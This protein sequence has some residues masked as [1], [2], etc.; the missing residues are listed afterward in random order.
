LALTRPSN[1]GLDDHDAVTPQRR[2]DKDGHNALA[3]MGSDRHRPKFGSDLMKTVVLRLLRGVP[4]LLY[5]RIWQNAGRRGLTL[6]RFAETEADG[7]RD[8]ARAAEL[9]SDPLLRRLYLVHANDER[10]HAE[11][12]RRRGAALLRALSERE[13]PSRQYPWLAPGERGIDD[14]RVDRETDGSLLAFL[15]LS[16]KTAASDLAA[17][18]DAL[19]G[20]PPTR[21]VF[22]EVLRDERFHTSYTLS[23]LHRIAPR[24]Q[25]LLLWRARASRLWK[26]YLRLA[27]TLAGAIGTL[28]LTLQYFVLLPPFA[29]LA[30]RAERRE[31]LGWTSIP[32]ERDA[33][34]ERQY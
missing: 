33:S 16:E 25:R 29:L 9:T 30:K 8:L 26:G 27:A 31:P 7:G 28:L 20:D 34:L 5:R 10:H 24:R 22:D 11:L 3:S 19:E 23:Q 18:R 13:R 14:L 21:A 15:H 12:F 17:Y 6:L 4:C 32:P 2:I 1:S